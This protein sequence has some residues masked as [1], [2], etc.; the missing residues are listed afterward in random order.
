MMGGSTEVR[1]E[2]MTIRFGSARKLVL[3]LIGVATLSIELEGASSG[4][5]GPCSV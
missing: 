2:S 3:C 4:H 5:L 1:C